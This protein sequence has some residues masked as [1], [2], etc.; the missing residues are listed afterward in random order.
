MEN[1]KARVGMKARLLSING[2]DFMKID[3]LLLKIQPGQT[4]ALKLSNLFGGNSVLGEIVNALLVNNSE[5]LLTDVYPQIE[6]Q[7]SETFTSIANR[8]TSE[9]SF[10]E[11]FPY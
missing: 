10:S 2:L 1:V 3:P 8:I 4:R 6:R 11:L 5:F 9:A 7:L